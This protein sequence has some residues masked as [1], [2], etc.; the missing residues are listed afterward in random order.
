[1]LVASA[2]PP[3][4]F[5]P[6]SRSAAPT[7]RSPTTPPRINNAGFWALTRAA[8]LD[9]AA[10]AVRARVDAVAARNAISLLGLRRVT[11]GPR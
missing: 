2:R 1:M 3:I 10:A 9:D 5:T 6:R 4:F 11:H 8:R 7:A